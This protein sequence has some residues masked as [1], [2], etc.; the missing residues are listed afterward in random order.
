MKD[1]YIHI[2]FIIDESGS[3][4][5]SSKDVTCGFQSMIEEQKKLTEGKCTISLFT[6]NSKVKEIFLGKD[7]NEIE[8]IDYF[9]YGS[10]SM[11]DGIGTAINKVGKWLSDMD[12]RERPSKN[13]IVIMTDGEENSS[14]EFTFN[15]VKEMISHQEEKY[16]WTFMYMGTDLTSMKQV[17]ELGIKMSS[18]SSRKDYT[19]N[20]K[21]VSDTTS[22]YRK[23]G[24]YQSKVVFD[25]LNAELNE[26]TNKYEVDNGIKIKQ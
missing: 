19:N 22:S 1:N 16:N 4:Y 8:N 10:T 18:F 21:I 2:C 12:E 7:V 9:P 26:V 20:Y 13:L 17:N 11:N 15:K 6:F 14:K 5:S 24:F 25:N 3:M 23:R